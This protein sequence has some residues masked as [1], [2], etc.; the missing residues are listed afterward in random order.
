MK[1]QEI[2]IRAAAWIEARGWKQKLA[3]QM[4]RA[5]SREAIGLGQYRLGP[6]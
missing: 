2:L 3:K 5:L 6:Q 1:R 4:V